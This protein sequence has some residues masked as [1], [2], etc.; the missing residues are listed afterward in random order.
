MAANNEFELTVEIEENRN[1][2]IE[3]HKLPKFDTASHE[4][5]ILKEDKLDLLSKKNGTIFFDNQA[6][7]YGLD[8]PR[9]LPP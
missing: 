6:A 5:D 3:K 9:I 4:I 8:K 2:I 7:F 1:K